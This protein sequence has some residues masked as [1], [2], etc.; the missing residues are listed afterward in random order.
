M[1]KIEQQMIDAIKDKNTLCKD[2]TSVTYN[3][4]T[5]SSAVYLH[6]NHI[7]TVGVNYVEIFDGG[8]QSV[9]TKSRLNAIISE[10]CG[11]VNKGVYQNKFEWFIRDDEDYDAHRVEFENGYTFAR[12]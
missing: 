2:N 8:W 1:R 9:T 4:Q 10:L 7:A 3:Y 12:V 5:D 11:G 6:G